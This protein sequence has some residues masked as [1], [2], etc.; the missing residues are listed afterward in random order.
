MKRRRD[1]LAVSL[2]QS[3]HVDAVSLS[4]LTLARCG[5]PARILGLIWPD[6]RAHSFTLFEAPNH[7]FFAYDQRGSIPLDGVRADSPAIVI[8]RAAYGANVKSAFWILGGPAKQP[9]GTRRLSP[10]E[11][12][13]NP[14]A[15]DRL[16]EQ[17]AA[18]VRRRL[19]PR[20]CR[21]PANFD[22]LMRA[23]EHE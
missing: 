22:V 16:L 8:A 13:N 2:P 18:P 5:V 14:P 23:L 10:N 3:C 12:R 21:T 7:K 15:L 17:D 11:C 4:W 6:G 20:E 19:S 9:P 1:K